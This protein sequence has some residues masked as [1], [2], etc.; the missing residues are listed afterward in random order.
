MEKRFPRA[1]KAEAGGA[2]VISARLFNYRA[3][4]F[5]Q[6]NP[7]KSYS[8]TKK[9]DGFDLH[10]HR[11]FKFCAVITERDRFA[12]RKNPSNKHRI[13]LVLKQQ[14]SGTVTTNHLL[15]PRQRGKAAFS[16]PIWRPNSDFLT[17]N[18]SPR[19]GPGAGAG[20]Q[21]DAVAETV[22]SM[23]SHGN[24]IPNGALSQRT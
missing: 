18:S 14:N 15:L 13:G 21:S 3:S 9:R 23:I 11:F 6:Y 8:R 22:G 17:H 2:K 24:F 1:G 4:A 19:D 5:D 20:G 10:R 16:L 12:R 7:G